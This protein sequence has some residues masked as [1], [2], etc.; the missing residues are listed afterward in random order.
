MN[1]LTVLPPEIGK[2][3]NLTR[4]DLDENKLTA[5]PPEI[6]KL[7]HLIELYMEGNRLTALPP[8]I[9]QLAGLTVLDLRANPLP[10]PPEILEVT[11][12]PARIINYYFEHLAGD[13]RP[14]NEA[15]MLIVGQGGVGKT[16]LVKRLVY[17]MVRRRN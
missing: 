16:S 6:G 1:N 9:R 10:I 13:K 14:L 2:L 15:K 8:E 5:L 11:H 4:I 3:T 17:D 7:A 12:D